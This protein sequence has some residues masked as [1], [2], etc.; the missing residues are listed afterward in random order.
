[1]TKS[2]GSYEMHGMKHTVVYQAWARMKRRCDDENELGYVNYG[3]RGIRHEPAWKKFSAFYADM[4]PMPSGYSLGR[5]D[6]NADYTKANCRWETREQ[7]NRNRRVFHNSSTRIAGV[8]WESAGWKVR[9]YHNKVRQTL[10]KG[11]DF[12]EACCVRKSWENKY[13]R[14]FG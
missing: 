4:G 1:M 8:T 11:P 5:K 7:Q 14:Q 13:A 2:Y 9:V 10:H 6:N 3:G 12:F